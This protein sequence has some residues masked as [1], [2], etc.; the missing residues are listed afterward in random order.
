M[1]VDKVAR[2]TRFIV[3]VKFIDI[4][5]VVYRFG[6]INCHVTCQKSDFK[7]VQTRFLPFDVTGAFFLLFRL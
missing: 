3:T 7:C 6:F 4:S 5:I 1:I 2:Q